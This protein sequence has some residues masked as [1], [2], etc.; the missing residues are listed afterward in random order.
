MDILKIPILQCRVCLLS[1]EPLPNN[2]MARPP[3]PD[4]TERHGIHLR[5]L[6][7][8]VNYDR[9]V[10]G[11]QVFSPPVSLQY[12]VVYGLISTAICRHASHE[13]SGF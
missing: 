1:M 12:P 6:S 2:S 3:T 11:V 5:H 8:L 7:T 4:S 13:T 10:P 9:S